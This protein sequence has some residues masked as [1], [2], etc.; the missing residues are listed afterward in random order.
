MKENLHIVGHEFKIDSD[1]RTL[2]NGHNPACLWFT[3]LSGS[4][5]STLAN[6]VE[7]QLHD[8]SFHTYILDGD[9]IR[10]GLNK[11]LNFSEQGRLEN[12]RRIGEVARLMMDAGLIV[13]AA[14]VTPFLKDRQMLRDMMGENYIEIFVDT[15][16]E[17]CE[18][19]DIK[20]LYQKAR[21]GEIPNFTG[22]SSPFERPSNPDIHIQTETQ[23][24]NDSVET[25]VKKILPKLKYNF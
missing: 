11:D 17:I 8:C 23:N 13:L 12:I 7:Q 22:I 25:I 19:R 3:G 10:K 2:K 21:S 24:I 4:G 18:Q 5:K 16:L 15:P 20:G 9:N 1:C 14:F 6:L